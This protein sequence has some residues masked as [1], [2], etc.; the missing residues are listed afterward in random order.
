MLQDR[1][2]DRSHLEEVSFQF[3]DTEPTVEEVFELLQT[4]FQG[5]L[6]KASQSIGLFSNNLKYLS[7][8]GEEIQQHL[9][10]AHREGVL[11]SCQE[12]ICQYLLDYENSPLCNLKACSLRYFVEGNMQYE[13]YVLTMLEALD[14]VDGDSFIKQGIASTVSE[15]FLKDVGRSKTRELLEGDG[16][17]IASIL[18]SS[19]V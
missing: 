18:N 6:Q 5:V 11:E 9:W 19:P 2:Q 4:I 17:V 13:Q 16:D 3:V 1:N 7:D 15:K 8:K 10:N 12:F 14:S